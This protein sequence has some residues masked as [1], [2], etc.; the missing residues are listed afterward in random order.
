MQFTEEQ[1]ITAQKKSKNRQIEILTYYLAAVELKQV[2][3]EHAIAYAINTVTKSEHGFIEAM[4]F[5]HKPFR[6]KAK[7]IVESLPDPLNPFVTIAH[8]IRHIEE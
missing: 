5:D 6:Q 8:A 2:S 3:H 1:Y 7:E 4:T